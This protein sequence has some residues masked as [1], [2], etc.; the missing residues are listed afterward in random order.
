MMRLHPLSLLVV[1][2]VT[3]AATLGLLLLESNRGD[4]Q[5]ARAREALDRTLLNEASAQAS[6]LE[7]QFSK[8]RSTLLLTVRNPAFA[9]FYAALGDHA[10]R[11]LGQARTPRQRHV[12]RRVERALGYLAELFPGSIGAA[13]F[14]DRSGAEIARGV[15]GE[16]I[17]DGGLIADKSDRKFFD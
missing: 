15:R 17:P 5:H 11:P 6:H 9:D 10:P 13:C 12:E 4:T 1:A 16:P 14:V 7:S 2:A 8:A 3:F